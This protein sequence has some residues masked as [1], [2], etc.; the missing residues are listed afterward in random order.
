MIIIIIKLIIL[1]TMMVIMMITIII[2]R[3]MYNYKYITDTNVSF[4][5][6]LGKDFYLLI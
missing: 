1:K 3:I 2:I 5:G 6:R 4:R